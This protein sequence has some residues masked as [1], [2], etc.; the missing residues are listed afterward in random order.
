MDQVANQTKR[1]SCKVT[2]HQKNRWDALLDI[3]ESSTSWHRE[4]AD[5]KIKVSLP[6]AIL[7]VVITLGMVAFI[8]YQ[9]FT[10]SW[11]LKDEIPMGD[12]CH[13]ADGRLAVEERAAEQAMESTLCTYDRQYDYLYGADSEWDYS[14]ATCKFKPLNEIAFK[15]AKSLHFVTYEQERTDVRIRRVGESCDEECQSVYPE[16]PTEAS[17]GEKKFQSVYVASEE[18]PSLRELIPDLRKAKNVHMQR[19]TRTGHGGSW[20]MCFSVQNKFMLGVDSAEF[21]FSYNYDSSKLSGSSKVKDDATPT[22]FFIGDG[23]N[24]D[25]PFKVQKNDGSRES[26]ISTLSVE[27]ALE[28]VGT[29][30]D[31][32]P[33]D[34]FFENALCEGS[35]CPEPYKLKPTPRVSGM[36]LSLQTEYYNDRKTMPSGEPYDTIKSDYDP[37]YAIHVLRKLEDWTSRGSDITVTEDTKDR[38]VTVDNYRY[39]TLINLQP[40]AGIISHWDIPSMVTGVCNFSV[41]M[42][43]PPVLIGLYI[44]YGLGQRSKLFRRGQRRNIEINDMYRGFAYTAM[45][46]DLAF[47]AFDKNGSGFVENEELKTSF[48]HLLMPHLE[49]RYPNKP[50]EFHQENLDKFVQL[51]VKDFTIEN[52]DGTSEVKRG[53]SHEEFLKYCTA[54]EP[55]DWDDVIEKLEDPDIDAA[56]GATIFKRKAKV[57]PA[58]EP[59]GKVL[60]A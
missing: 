40:A 31:G 60:G 12:I 21:H 42:G 26:G 10:T 1:L 4:P 24:K 51:L 39:G 3:F 50:T 7:K 41:L 49:T 27:E 9:L 52:P 59:D 28:A 43:F 11:Y 16:W 23:P 17:Y 22:R 2:L 18:D 36:Q 8:C 19:P 56:R 37:P 45:M 33:D 15:G 58:H 44:F 13:Y 54:N 29:S 38:K 30:L 35:E 32:M 34:I 55:L 6:T 48:R 5:V 46:A 25:K 53:V 14:G 57:A 20:C 47:K